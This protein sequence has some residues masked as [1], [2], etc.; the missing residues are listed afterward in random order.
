[1]VPQSRHANGI[2]V[3]AFDLTTGAQQWSFPVLA[4]FSTN[5]PT[6]HNG[7]VYFQRGK[8]SNDA[9]SP[10]LF[11]LNA[12]TGAQI[13]A[14]VFAAQSESYEA[15]S[16]ND[17]GIFING[18][19]YGG[20]YGFNPDGSQRFFQSL[21]QV[22]GWT[23][24]LHKDRLFSFVGNTFTEH[25]PADG[26]TIWSLGNLSGTNVVAAQG[27]SAVLSS[28]SLL[29]CID[30]P[31]R[32]VRWQKVA[33]F[34]GRPAM[35]A[36]KAY[37]IQGN[38]VRSYAL[39][40]GTPGPVFQTVGSSSSLLDQP[41]LFNDR[42]LI[43][44]STKT[45]VFNLADGRLLQTLSA[46]GRLSYS[47]GYLLAAG[48]D[49]ILR[50]FL[51]TPQPRLVVERA[52]NP[53]TST[54]V[55]D[56]PTSLIGQSS[57]VELTLRNTGL[58]ELSGLSATFALV[59]DYSFSSAPPTTIAPGASATFTVAF[60]PTAPG[61][62]TATLRLLSND[63]SANPFDL[64][65]TGK[66]NRAPIFAGYEVTT[67]VNRPLAL[68]VRKILAKAS[69]PDGDVVSLIQAITPGNKGGIA[70][71]ANGAITYTPPVGFTGTETFEVEL[72][73]TNGAKIRGTVTVTVD[74]GPNAGGVGSNP[75]VLTMLPGGKIGIAFQG[76]P[77]RTY[78]VERSIGGLDNWLTI[79]TL[80]A[81][82]IGKVY[83]VDE[84]PPP[85]SAYYRLALP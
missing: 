6:V 27:D 28:S 7:R 78:L 20:M 46:G 67:S 10:Q 85:G 34:S 12:D 58:G 25:N 76:I 47:N 79:A 42:L 72:S 54:A 57:S 4:S 31:S 51:A 2:S 48:T 61:T 66:G 77:G 32:S 23:P 8:G 3:K 45:W 68:A 82:A 49:G 24:T 29:T 74:P 62:R 22:D 50:A 35:A 84:S 69:D 43:S 64:M 75:P 14:S 83:Y 5:P 16:V 18:G 37:A 81:D 60:T 1:V 73:D 15:P 52:G 56:F 71:L 70:L 13:W 53:L 59:G 36:G 65:L 44:D 26:S 30:L 80:V 21:A 41:V 19:T 38:A 39:A 11:C 40:D 55:V 9:S 63:S 17:Q 33:S